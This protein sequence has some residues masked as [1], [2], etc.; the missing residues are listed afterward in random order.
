MKF[1]C[2]LLSEFYQI[3]NEPLGAIG[4]VGCN[5]GRGAIGDGGA[6]GDVP[7]FAHIYTKPNANY[8]PHPYSLYLFSISERI[9]LKEG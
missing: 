6:I 9:K 2:L 5:W 3:K 1:L 8:F 7:V 4:D